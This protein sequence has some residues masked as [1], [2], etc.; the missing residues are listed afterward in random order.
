MK[1][2]YVLAGFLKQISVGVI[3]VGFCSAE[4]PGENLTTS[5]LGMLPLRHGDLWARAELAQELPSSHP[6]PLGM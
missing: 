1:Q 6:Q 2:I 4:V 5:L 3:T